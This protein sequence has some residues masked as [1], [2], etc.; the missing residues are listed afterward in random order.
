M[1]TRGSRSEKQTKEEMSNDSGSDEPLSSRK[2]RRA[3]TRVSRE[4]TPSRSR[5][6]RKTVGYSEDKS[7]D[8]DTDESDQPIPRKVKRSVKDTSSGESTPTRSRRSKKVVKYSDVIEEESDDE[9]EEESLPDRRKQRDIKKE[10]S[11]RSRKTKMPDIE[12]SKVD[13]ENNEINSESDDEEE[14]KS[15]S[16]ES[17]P[18]KKKRS[19][20][21]SKGKPS[22][23]AGRSRKQVDS[24]SS[25]DSSVKESRVKGARKRKRRKKCDDD[26]G[27]S[28]GDFVSSTKTGYGR[29]TTGRVRTKVNSNSGAEFESSTDEEDVIAVRVMEDID[30]EGID[31]VL[32]HRLGKEG[33][34][35][36]ATEHFNV[37]DK[38]DPNET[39]DTDRTEKQYLI[40]WKDKAHIYNTWETD[41]SIDAKKI[42]DVKVKGFIKLHKYQQRESEF[43]G[44]K[45]RANPEDVE[46]QEIDIQLG[47][48]LIKTYKEAERVFCRRKNDEEGTTEFFVKW[49]N[50][51]YSEATWEV[52]LTNQISGLFV[53]TNHNP[54]FSG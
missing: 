30:I 27:D 35:G 4:S 46:F 43:E 3:N 36:E 29:A 44:W 52:N 25:D 14:D 32:D 24:D 28:D 47:R 10:H 51:P 21:S 50:L 33:A 6:A 2:S 49:R 15:E 42:G 9:E 41:D 22:R 7:D 40:K 48:E 19:N 53:S 5:R 18:A 37:I 26:D 12:D 31:K 38:G 20:Y 13:S 23:N 34:T 16:P 1:P 17:P 45:K 54:S 8:K 39:L 11:T